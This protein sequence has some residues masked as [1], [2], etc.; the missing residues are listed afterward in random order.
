VAY[1]GLGRDFE[2]LE[3]L[4]LVSYATV[5]RKGK[6]TLS[7]ESDVSGLD[8]SLLP[9]SAFFFSIVQDAT[10]LDV[11]LVSTKDDRDVL[12]NPLQIS[13]PVRNV[14]VGDSG[15]NIKH[16]D[17]TL[18]LDVVTISETTEFL[19]SSGIPNVEADG[20]EVGVES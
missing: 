20:T 16:D 14:L 15:S 10:D 11:D 7:V 3:V 1:V 13:V 18:S 19:L 5:T 4:C 12:T 6:L 9:S 8:L 17:T 2:V